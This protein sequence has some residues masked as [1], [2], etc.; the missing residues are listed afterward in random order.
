MK[1]MNK[2]LKVIFTEMCNR[3]DAKYED[4]DFQKDDWYYDY[5]WTQAEEDKFLAWLADYLYINKKARVDLY[6][7]HTKSKKLCDTASKN[8]CFYSWKI[9]K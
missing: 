2:Y 4:I 8:F 6:G 1:K 5:E 9:K 7:I 3:V